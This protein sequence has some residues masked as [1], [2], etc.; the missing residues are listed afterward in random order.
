[1]AQL[2]E[3]AMADVS[4]MPA[5]VQDTT[6]TLVLDELR[7]EHF[8]RRPEEVKRLRVELTES[9]KPIPSIPFCISNRLAVGNPSMP[10]ESAS[11]G[12][13]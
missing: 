12:G 13:H 11:A 10:C 2:L 8:E 4:K 9:S 5:T 7:R 1:M 3:Q 6:A